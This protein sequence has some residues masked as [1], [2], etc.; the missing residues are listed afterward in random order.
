MPQAISTSAIGS[1][2]I[3]MKK[4]V[5]LIAL[6]VSGCASNGP[7]TPLTYWH[8]DTI[9]QD[10][11]QLCKH[12]GELETV[13]AGLLAELGYKVNSENY[14][15]SRIKTHSYLRHAEWELEQDIEKMKRII[16]NK[17]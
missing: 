2:W 9:D 15:Q 7:E 11:P 4:F 10:I 8:P 14:I 3:K 13:R 17:Q 5:I 6:L 16:Q 1:G 12:I